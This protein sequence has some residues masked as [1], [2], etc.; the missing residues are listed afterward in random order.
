MNAKIDA[1]EYFVKMFPDTGEDIFQIVCGSVLEK[2]CNS[3]KDNFVEIKRFIDNLTQNDIMDIY[4]ASL[5]NRFPD[6]KKGNIGVE[7]ARRNSCVNFN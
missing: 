6:I 5:R 7:I 4:Y 2:L 1:Q 3:K